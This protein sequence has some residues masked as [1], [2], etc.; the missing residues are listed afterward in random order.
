MKKV[1]W[2][3]FESTT[4]RLLYSSRILFRCGVGRRSRK[5]GREKGQA[6]FAG[7][8][9]HT[10]GVTE[11]QAGELLVLVSHCGV[12]GGRGSEE[13]QTPREE[14]SINAAKIPGSIATGSE[15]VEDSQYLD[16]NLYRIFKC[17]S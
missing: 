1:L 2:I 13:G 4:P 11:S 9:S 15:R 12:S 10:E 14:L 16:N 3:L 6:A 8:F 17:F 7:S 5:V